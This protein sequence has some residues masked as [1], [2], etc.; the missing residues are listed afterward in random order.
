VIQLIGDDRV[1]L[2]GDGLK[3]SFIRIPAGSVEDRVLG[4]EK[5][6]DAFFELPVNRLRAADEADGRQSVSEI[7][8]PFCRCLGD[9]GM[10][11]QSE[12]IVGGEHDDVAES[13]DVDH[14]SLRRFH[15]QLAFERAGGSHLI[16]LGLQR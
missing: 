13:F 3:E 10:V 2:Q 15:Q 12:V 1:L 6:G 11:G 5:G 4:S 7:A 8:L 9:G 14:R 16:E